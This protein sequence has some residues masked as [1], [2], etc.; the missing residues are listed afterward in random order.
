[1]Y[2]RRKKEFWWT[3]EKVREMAEL[4]RDKKLIAAE[5]GRAYGISGPRVAQLFKKFG[6]PRVK[7]SKP[8]EL[9]NERFM[10]NN[11]IPKDV[12][13]DLYVNKKLRVEDILKYLKKS[14]RDFYKSLE[15]YS[16][17]KRKVFDDNSPSRLAYDL[18]H[19]MYIEEELTAKEIAAEFGCS[20]FSIEKRLAKLGIRKTQIDPAPVK[21]PNRS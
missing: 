12:L 14:S 20:P 3:E 15:I 2:K 6:I 9:K 7:R 11:L 1:M 16:I 13:I 17:P 8:Q 19:R 21:Q 4:C 10:K 18:L 5:A